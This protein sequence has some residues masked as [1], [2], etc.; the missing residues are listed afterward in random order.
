[1]LD[2]PQGAPIEVV[3]AAHRKHLLIFHPDK[4]PSPE[5]SAVSQGLNA[6]FEVVGN[7]ET[8]AKTEMLASKAPIAPEGAATASAATKRGFTSMAMGATLKVLSI[9]GLV[10]STLVGLGVGAAVGIASGACKGAVNGFSTSMATSY[11]HCFTIIPKQAVWLEALETALSSA[12]FAATKAV[13]ADAADWKTSG[14]APGGISGGA[15]LPAVTG[16]WDGTDPTPDGE[17]ASEDVAS[18]EISSRSAALQGGTQHGHPTGSLRVSIGAFY[19]PDI[20]SAIRQPFIPPRTSKRGAEG[21]KAFVLWAVEIFNE[22]A[23]RK[24]AN[25]VSPM[26]AQ[27]PIGKLWVAF[28]ASDLDDADSHWMADMA[29]DVNLEALGD[30]IFSGR[31]SSIS[32]LLARMLDA[33]LPLWTAYASTQALVAQLTGAT[34]PGADG[35][36]EAARVRPDKELVPD[37]TL[38]DAALL[39]AAEA[40]TKP[41]TRTLEPLSL[42]VEISAEHV[43]TQTITTPLL[44][45]PQPPAPSG[46]CGAGEGTT[47][48]D[49][50]HSCPSAAAPELPPPQVSSGTWLAS[51]ASWLANSA[52]VAVGMAPAARSVAAGPGVVVNEIGRGTSAWRDAAVA[53]EVTNT[54]RTGLP[55]ASEALASVRAAATQLAHAAS[56]GKRVDAKSLATGAVLTETGSTTVLIRV[57]ATRLPDALAAAVTQGAKTPTEI[58]PSRASVVSDTLLSYSTWVRIRNPLSSPSLLQCS[59]LA[60]PHR[61]LKYRQ[62]HRRL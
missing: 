32:V 31:V 3:R 46:A 24:R 60:E 6:A 43:L 15:G 25:E 34:G 35:V 45:L 4:N 39:R 48:Q 42:R 28:L 59:P 49:A 13:L 23:R 37:L 22:L 36:P 54:G 40:A 26:L 11:D 58:L 57:V 62:D 30:L 9:S 56:K 27:I 53:T 41:Q 14:P 1:V 12:C 16:L 55:V 7:A 19:A 52:L 33:W 47:Q 17:D 5:A 18:A 20:M 50:E 44:T 8:R 51:S 61:P 2:V 29:R 10:A 21:P 38:W